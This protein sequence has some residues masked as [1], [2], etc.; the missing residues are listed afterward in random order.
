MD[1]AYILTRHEPEQRRLR[2]HS[3]AAV[4]GP[5]KSSPAEKTCAE[6]FYYKK[7]MQART[8]MVI[9]LVDGQDVR[10]CI[11]WYDKDCLKVNRD[12]EPNLLV[13]KRYIVYM[14]KAQEEKGEK[15]EKGEKGRRAGRPAKPRSS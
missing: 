9:K 1:R 3:G 14:Y 5:R 13:M 11:E 10:G 12:D 7:Q 4:T 8:H 6:E 2:S 15:A